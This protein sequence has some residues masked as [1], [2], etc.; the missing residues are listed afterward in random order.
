LNT[1][2][3]WCGNLKP[4]STL[5]TGVPDEGFSDLSD[6]VVFFVL[7]FLYDN[8]YV[9]IVLVVTQTIIYKTLRKKTND[10]ATR[11]PLKPV[12]RDSLLWNVW[13]YH[14]GNL[15]GY[16]DEEQ[17]IKQKE[18]KTNNCWHNTL[19]ITPP[20]IMTN[21]TWCNQ[22]WN[23]YIGAASVYK[24]YCTQVSLLF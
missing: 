6:G 11:T 14:R 23:V 17:G 19:L 2:L 15:M 13:R 12:W 18:I 4:L 5:I 7:H 20:L 10:W 24:S 22:T 9:S 21:R 3:Y 8:Y 1:Y 16:I